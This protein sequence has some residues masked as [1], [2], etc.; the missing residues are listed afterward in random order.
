MNTATTEIQTV[1]NSLEI[2]S[3]FGIE[4]DLSEILAEELKVGL[5]NDANNY[6]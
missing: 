3:Q 6:I 2:L 5:S 1:D 4:I